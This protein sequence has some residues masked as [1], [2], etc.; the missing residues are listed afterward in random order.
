MIAL[1]I[2]DMN[3]NNS[4]H[5]N[6]KDTFGEVNDPHGV[7][8]NMMAENILNKFGNSGVPPHIQELKVGDICIVLR[9]LSIVM[10]YKIMH[11]NN[12]N[13]KI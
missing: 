4:W 11:S 7:L 6:S 1:V 2:Q 13:H 9:N 5:L 3:L 12:T 10:V 8:A